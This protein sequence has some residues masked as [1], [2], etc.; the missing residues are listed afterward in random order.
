MRST[1][2]A[3]GGIALGLMVGLIVL[4]IGLIFENDPQ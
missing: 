2:L 4:G 3:Y 1:M